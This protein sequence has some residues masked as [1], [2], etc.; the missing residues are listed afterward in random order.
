MTQ[1][2]SDDRNTV[3][4]AQRALST[5][6]GLAAERPALDALENDE[7]LHLW[8][9]AGY[10][11]KRPLDRLDHDSEE[12]MARNRRIDFR[13]VMAPVELPELEPVP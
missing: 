12:A 5:L 11:S 6:K 8:S 13:F 7:D 2:Q 1:Q 4:S 10:G 9:V 3:L